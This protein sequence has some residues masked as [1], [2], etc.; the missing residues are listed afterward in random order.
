MSALRTEHGPKHARSLAS[1]VHPALLALTS[2]SA[3]TAIGGGVGVLVTGLG[4]PKSQL[5][6]TP[7]DSFLVPGLLLA[8]AVGGSLATAAVSLLQRVRWQGR[9]AMASGGVMLGWIAVESLMIHDG[10]PLQIAVAVTSLLI[11]LLG[12]LQMRQDETV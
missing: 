4:I 2:F 7:F 1:I 10:R 11:L 8:I 5:E 12:W 9:V 3:L 6:G